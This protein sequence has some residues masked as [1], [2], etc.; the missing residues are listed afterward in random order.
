LAIDVAINA[1]QLFH[2]RKLY[3]SG[4]LRPSVA[5]AGADETC[6]LPVSVVDKVTAEE[7]QS[8]AVV[9]SVVGR[10]HIEFPGMASVSADPGLVA[11]RDP[12]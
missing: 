5:D 1:N 6:L 2:Q 7:A 8:A 10:I 3:Q 4:L 12:L 11:T 9:A